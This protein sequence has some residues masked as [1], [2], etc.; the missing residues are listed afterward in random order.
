MLSTG[1]KTGYLYTGCAPF[2]VPVYRFLAGKLPL[3]AYLAPGYLH[4]GK[5]KTNGATGGVAGNG[6]FGRVGVDIH[7]IS[8]FTKKGR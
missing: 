6:F 4:R 3:S 8:L 2:A 7:L 1:S 5:F